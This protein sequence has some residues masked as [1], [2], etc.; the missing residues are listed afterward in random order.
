MLLSMNSIKMLG[1]I[2]P[3]S[4][5][6]SVVNVQF[7]STALVSPVLAEVLLD[8]GNVVVEG[9]SVDETGTNET[10]ASREHSPQTHMMHSNV[11][12][13]KPVLTLNWFRP[14]GNGG[15]S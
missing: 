11:T 3:M 1:R 5:K 7:T 4:C 10:Q 8:S 2:T 13:R 14:L 12:D 6:C 15:G 9:G